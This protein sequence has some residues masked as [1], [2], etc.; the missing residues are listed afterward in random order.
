LSLKDSFLVFLN[1]FI[2]HFPASYFQKLQHIK[3][4]R[5]QAEI[6]LRYSKEGNRP[7][8]VQRVPAYL[9]PKISGH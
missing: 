8:V 5:Q 1:T 6:E 7:G 4:I 9:G 3:S 2:K